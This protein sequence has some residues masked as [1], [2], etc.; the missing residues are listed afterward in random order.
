M[1][2]PSCALRIEL[3]QALPS[4]RKPYLYILTKQKETNQTASIPKDRKRSSWFLQISN[5]Y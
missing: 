2:I 4:P 3:E 1:M 5:R